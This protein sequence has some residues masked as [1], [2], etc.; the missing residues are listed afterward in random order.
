MESSLKNV[1]HEDKM[2]IERNTSASSTDYEIHTIGCN[3]CSQRKEETGNTSQGQSLTPNTNLSATSEPQMSSMNIFWILLI[4]IL[5]IIGLVW[6]MRR[7][8][9][10]KMRR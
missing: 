4:V 9:G 7:S 5:L 10:K 3:V 2:G 6:L 8:K 1:F